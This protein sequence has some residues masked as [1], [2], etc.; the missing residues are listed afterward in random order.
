[1]LIPKMFLG[2]NPR[3]AGV[4]SAA[5]DK[6]TVGLMDVTISRVPTQ[7]HC[8]TLPRGSAR[9]AALWEPGNS[10]GLNSPQ[11]LTGRSGASPHQSST[12]NA[13]GAKP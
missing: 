9:P 11:P 2:R 1:V 6:R 13:Y 8:K 12:P 3:R 4:C 7:G 10:T 5:A